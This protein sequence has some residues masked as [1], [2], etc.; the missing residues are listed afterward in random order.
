[1][2]GAAPR[3]LTNFAV[4]WHREQMRSLRTMIHAYRRCRQAHAKL[5]R[6]QRQLLTLVHALEAARVQQGGAEFRKLGVSPSE[7]KSCSF[8]NQRLSCSD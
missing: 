7:Q 8:M 1:M 4:G 3:Y 2:I 6:G 5:V